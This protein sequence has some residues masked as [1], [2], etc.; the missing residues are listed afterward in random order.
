[1]TTVALA[2]VVLTA[3][4]SAPAP[5]SSGPSPSSPGSSAAEAPATGALRV[6][7][8]AEGLDKPWDVTWVR[9]RMLVT[10]REGT[11]AT[12]TDGRETP[13]RAD[14]ASVYARGEGGLMG[15]A[16]Y[17]DD[18]GRF[19]TCQT[20][21]EGGRPVDVRVVAWQLSADGASATRTKD[22]LVG[23]LPINPSG[24]HSGC[25]PTFGPDGALWIG[26]GDTARATI[27]QDRTA[28]GG[29]VLR[30]DPETGGPA[31]GNPFASSGSAAERL[32]SGYGHRNVQA[33]AFQPGTGTGWSVEHGPDVDDEVN[34]VIPGRNY[35]WDPARGGES[36]GGYDEGV[37]M[38]DLQRYPDAVPA[39][40][41]SGDPTIATS[42]GA[43]VSGPAWGDLDGAL[44]VTAQKGEKLLFMR[45]GTGADAQRIVSV[46]TPPEL[47]G[48][49]GRLR[50]A[51]VGPDGALY[52]TTDNGNDDVIL[53]V[54]RG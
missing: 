40:W 52:L 31:A 13:V 45:P 2:A 51:R 42:G 30:V 36:P 15:M 37:P 8:V 24:R 10:Q 29:K 48:E 53:R 28:L 20:H 34:V 6:E 5:T 41:S 54:T 19:V 16:A 35:G 7:R 9:D 26:T 49:F 39:A 18:S 50:G 21:Q 27:P 11:L 23:G 22:P 14:L 43:F 47:D 32:V 46:S 17:P 3:C 38:T 1:M 44:A 12:I 33:V 4:S 25:R